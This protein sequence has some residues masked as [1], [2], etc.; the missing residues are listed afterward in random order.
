MENGTAAKLAP[1]ISKSVTSA[2]TEKVPSLPGMPVKVTCV[3][4]PESAI[5]PSGVA[6]LLDLSEANTSEICSR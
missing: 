5:C 4:D 3:F 6:T 2:L 1:S